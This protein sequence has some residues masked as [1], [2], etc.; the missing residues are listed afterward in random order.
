MKSSIII[1]KIMVL[2]LFISFNPIANAQNFN[3]F[4]HRYDISENE[5][6]DDC[7][8]IVETEDGYVLAGSSLVMSENIYWWEKKL[9]KINEQGIIQ[10]V[11]TYG[12]DSIDYFFTNSGC[13]IKDVNHFYAVGKRRT[14]TSNGIHDEGTLMYLNEN[15]DTLWMRKYGEKSEPFDTAYLFTCLQILNQG[16]LI[17]AGS[18]K[19][20]GLAS[21]AYLLKTNSSGQYIWDK[22]FDDGDYIDAYSITQTSDL[23]F[24]LGCFEQTPG[25]PYTVDP[26][27]IKTDSLGNHE[28]TKN[29]GGPYKDF[30]PMVTLSIDGDI[31]VGTSYADSML[32]PDIPLSRINLIKL[33]N[34]GNILWNKK[35]GISQANNYL[36]NIRVLNDG[37]IITV[38][39]L[40]KY[41]P[42]PD[43]VGWIFKTSAEGDSMW[44]RE[45][46]YLSGYESKNYLFDIMGTNDDGLI[47]CGYVIPYSP[48][49]GSID[50]WV[51]KLDSIGC[52]TAGCDPTVGIKEHGSRGAGEQGGLEV[53]P[54]PVREE[55]HV[56]LNMDDG[57][58]YKDLRLKI[59]DVFGR[60][61]VM[62]ITPSPAVGEGWGGGW[63]ADVSALP[64]GIYLAVLREGLIIKA[65]VKFLVA[66]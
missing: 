42:D 1:S 18:W 55:I 48:D 37:S 22:S 19:P 56:R 59:Y 38:G 47:A 33:D 64:P 7:I 13:I 61:V 11:K 65:S 16:N 49:T 57:R 46:R 54:N 5:V 63:T 32:T 2:G 28:W 14:A 40:R 62:K 27:I 15:L 34:Y 31:L 60:E 12:E 26:F 53:W 45:Y 52:D 30:N 51:I 20:Y 43:R 23:G 39:G 58:F 10:Y 17:I 9:S 29:L 21:H 6:E 35:Y 25:Y 8:A 41:N 66:R 50:T 3:Y 24:I 44:Y 4:N 36:R